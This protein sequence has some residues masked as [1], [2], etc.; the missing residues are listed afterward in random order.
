MSLS[1]LSRPIG[2]FFSFEPSTRKDK[3]LFNA[4][5]KHLRSLRLQ[6][7]I[8]IQELYDS[9]IDPGSNWQ[10][11]IETYINRADLIVL[12]I[13]ADFFASERCYKIEM[14][15]ALA[16]YEAGA[17]RILG[18][19]LRPID[20][21]YWN[22]PPLDKTN[23]LP[24]G[25]RAIS[26]WPDTD[27]ALVE[28]V[29]GIRKVVEELAE[30]LTNVFVRPGSPKS[31]LWHV[32]YRRN[33]FFT[34]RKDILNALHNYFI[35]S[36]STVTRIQALSGLGGVGKTQLALEYAY[37]YKQDYWSVLWVRADSP[38]LLRAD[39]STIAD[40]LFLPAKE[41]S[42]EQHLFAAIQRWLQH[43]Q[44]WLLVLD[45]LNPEDF[46]IIDHLV[47][48]QCSG[49]VLLTTQSQATGS[50]ARALPV[51]PMTIDEG[52]LFL[53]R[54]AKIISEQAS[55]DEASKEDYAE[56][57]AIAQELG[58]L[59]L[60]L[61]QAGAYIEETQRSLSAYLARYRQR[62]I[63]LLRKR[64]Q[65]S[66]DHDQSVSVT[67]SMA[68]QKVS[69]I[70]PAA[71]DLL[72]LFAFLHPDA[73][74]D[75]M[76]IDGA[77][78][79]NEPLQ[80]LAADPLD[81]DAAISTL[82][83]FSL[84]RHHADTTTL[85]IHRL[86]QTILKDEL[87]R[88][89]QSQWATSVVRLVNRVFPDAD[90]SA[91]D[92]C[93]RYLPQA[94][95]CAQLISE[96]HL[97]LLE[98]GQLLYRLGCYCQ[99]RALY[100][101]AERHLMDALRLSEQE[102]GPDHLTTAEYLNAL[103]S[104]YSDLG[105]YQQAELLQQ[106]ALAIHEQL[107]GPAHIETAAMLN[108]LGLIYHDQEKYLLAEALY[109][110]TLAIYKAT[111]PPGHYRI[112]HV[113]NNL[114][115]L[116]Q[117]QEDHQK[118]EDIFLQVLR[119]REETLEAEH[120]DIAN[121]LNNLAMFYE[122]QQNYQRAE[123]LLVRALH[124]YEHTKGTTHPDVAMV[125]NNLALLYRKQERY[126]QAEQLYLRALSIYEQLFGPEHPEVA[127]VLNNLGKLYLLQDQYLQAESLLQRAI[128]IREQALGSQHS[129]TAA[130]LSNL[131]ELYT[132][133]GQYQ[134]AE[135]LYLRVLDIDKQVHG[136][137]HTIVAIDL[138]KYAA[139]LECTQRAEEAH[140]LQQDVQHIRE[141]HKQIS[142]SS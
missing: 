125:L 82:L 71:M 54:R 105:N 101:E 112:T 76:L 84:V 47:P 46:Q 65:F 12:L 117:E 94:Q 128:A 1:S 87:T 126:P 36:P 43:N 92:L 19:I 52:A 135:A 91:N 78:E 115:T 18:V 9:E 140:L 31:P 114:A 133:Q 104:L 15:Q 42:D 39:I 61:D 11:V 59:P 33:C 72:R 34:G 73:I 136:P 44:R 102:L 123:P 130:S 118:A 89:L 28:V 132:R 85:S 48:A 116:Y 16:R 58:G 83:R 49:H 40:L 45:N 121:S 142:S 10:Q 68:F 64:G 127:R 95:Q 97:T 106:R 96:F 7:S 55:R 86:V 103:A 53:L 60:A 110:R 26:Q 129:D 37:F 21:S 93:E 111:L 75:Q 5:K 70:N 79:L 4:L 69:R 77:S 41:R 141:R 108:N 67:L 24:P 81:L 98:A 50:L 23:L 74:P 113:L 138:E 63:T 62:R 17:A 3:N 2:I 8:P 56:A 137:E 134:Q 29:K 120:P 119:I 100:S 14:Q 90:C 99:Q 88:A 35:S 131:A 122:E 32:P 27:E 80:A 109:Q 66:N 6:S 20:T 22:R 124:I 25:G 38:D 51:E 57:V 107:L 30:R 139:L 13:S